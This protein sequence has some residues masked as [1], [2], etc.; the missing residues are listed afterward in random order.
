MAQQIHPRV[1]PKDTLVQNVH[2]II[3]ITAKIMNVKTMATYS[4]TNKEIVLHLY[5]EMLFGNKNE[6][7]TTMQRIMCIN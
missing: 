4:A 5:N 3:S 7:I 2:S 6:H 1:Y